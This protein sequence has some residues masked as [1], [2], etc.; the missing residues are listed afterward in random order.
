MMQLTSSGKFTAEPRGNFGIV[1]GVTA[2]WAA[3]LG[4]HPHR[5]GRADSLQL[6]EALRAAIRDGRLT[7]GSKLPSTRA[8]AQELG[9]ARGTVTRAYQQLTSEGFLL[10]RQGA[11]TVVAE[12]LTTEPPAQPT[13]TADPEPAPLWDFRPG[14]PDLS[15]FPRRDWLAASRRALE[16]ASAEDL[17][18]GDPQGHPALREALS[19]YLSRARAVVTSPDRIVICNG[20]SQ[21]LALLSRVL[22]DQGGKSI[23]FEDP[24]VPLLRSIPARLGLSVRGVPVDEKGLAVDE[25]TGDAAVITPA[26]Q[27]P[28]GVALSS[29]RR[30]RLVKLARAGGLLVL[31]D[32][33]DGEFRFDR[34]P[35]GAIQGLAPEDVVYAGTASKTLAPALRLAWLAVPHR[36]VEPLREL[37]RESGGHAPLVEQLTMAQLIR[38]GAYDQ[39]IRRSRAVYRKRRAALLEALGGLRARH[40]PVPAGVSAG[41]HLTLLLDPRG[42]AEPDVLQRARDCSVGLDPLGAHWFH[43]GSHPGGLVL[44]YASPAGDAFEPALQALLAVLEDR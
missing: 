15:S 27:Y 16:S 40:R 25:I 21:A 36:L 38:S 10:S 28:L 33:Y 19:D 7:A 41:L 31:E 12:R 8:L 35:I 42:E 44:G 22:Q 11:P 1:R 34:P 37:K 20:Y 2:G 5:T 6:A 14:R 30:T 26:H 13:P 17:G 29:A 18:Y 43:P 9:M 24:S 23:D 4:M 3:S 32:D 39:H